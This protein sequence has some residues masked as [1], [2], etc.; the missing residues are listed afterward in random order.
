LVVFLGK[1]VLCL[2]RKYYHRYGKSEIIVLSKTM[3]MFS[4]VLED[5]PKRKQKSRYIIV[6]IF[7]IS[8]SGFIGWYGLPYRH[9]I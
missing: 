7:V 5:E 9:I 2:S 8:Y 1:F 6:I 3:I 4:R